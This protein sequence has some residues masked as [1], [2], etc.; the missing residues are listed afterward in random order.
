MQSPVAL[1]APGATLEGLLLRASEL[2]CCDGVVRVTYPSGGGLIDRTIVIAGDDVSNALIGGGGLT[3]RNSAIYTGSVDGVAVAGSTGGATLVNV[4]A[5]SDPASPVYSV[6]VGVMSNNC[7][8]ENS[9]LVENSIV[10]GAQHDFVLS[11]PCPAGGAVGIDA[12]YSNFDPAKV[13]SSEAT[14]L[15]EG[16]GNQ[17]GAP[18][19]LDPANAYFDQLEASST[20]NAGAT[21]LAQGSLDLNG[22]A[23]VQE[24]VVDIGADEFEPPASSTT[25]PSPNAAP[26]LEHLRVTDRRFA[27]TRPSKR[28][29][30]RVNQGST[31]F[32]Y[33]LSEPASVTFE[34][35]RKVTGR[36]V[37]GE[38]KRPT[39]ANREHRPCTLRYRYIGLFK[40][41]GEQGGN[42]AEFAG[43]VRAR[44]GS[45]VKLSLGTYRATAI[46]L[47]SAGAR[48]KPRSAWF[49]VVRR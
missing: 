49:R 32:S 46:A 14:E 47:D 41:S 21:T 30:R 3:I 13:Q 34:I 5:I 42:T 9:I 12:R 37:G 36:R 19:L 40:R 10:S 28:V 26:R 39:R 24:G 38:C 29:R 35:H 4:T 17:S 25:G 6:N 7:Y 15:T 48:S 20:R 11:Q 2:G 1:F 22:D 18:S 16:P 45:R 33:W 44:N 27:T 23:R 8:G 31:T 43:K